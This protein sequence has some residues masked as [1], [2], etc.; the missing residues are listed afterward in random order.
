MTQGPRAE[1]LALA[2][3]LGTG[4]PKVA[5]V[6][7]DGQLRWVGQRESATRRSPDGTAVQDARLWW[8][9]VLSL[10]R[11]G[12]TDA[13][14]DPAT[15]VAVSVTGQWGSTVPVDERGEPV[16]DAR[17]FLDTRG[18]RHSRTVIGGPAMGYHPGRAL[19]WLRRTGG[20]PS[21]HGGDPIAH[22]LAIQHDEP[23]VAAAARWFLEPVDYL[24]M[25]FCGRAV[26]TPNSM[27]LAWLTD[28]RV[29]SDS[30]DYQPDLLAHSGIHGR[31][32]APLIPTGSIVGPLDP[33]VAELLGLRRA[34]VVLAGATDLLTASVGSGALADRQA[35]LAISTTSW[36]SAPMTVKKTDVL[37][38]IATVPGLSP[39]RYLIANN[40]ETAGVCLAWARDQ[41][42]GGT[43]PQLTAEA[44]TAAP[45]SGG[46]LF[47][48][49]LSGLRSPVDDRRARGGW[50]NASLAT[51]RAELIRSVMEGVALQ[52]GWLLQSVEKFA[53]ARLDPIRVI[54]GGAQSDLW[55][56]LHADV[57]D[58]RIER[59]ADPVNAQLRGAA[60]LAALALGVLTEEQVS[61]AGVVERVFTPDPAG[62]A[63]YR[64]VARAFRKL[65]GRQ[66]AMFAELNG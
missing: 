43:F 11:T 9:D 14:V 40:H 59:V 6:T 38:S 65:Y 7:L 3:D 52:S 37:H 39:G 49:W 30:L 28:N 55:C 21:P 35:H 26:A 66:K 51:T 57:L 56:Q 45:G 62:R 61:A 2:V 53:G 64:P 34:V 18:A 47:A 17:L 25:R 22:M 54:G 31:R 24:T 16:G 48:P 27:T 50:H 23:E 4:G 5:L 33:T 63:A 41:V 46:V 12:L 10:A 15:V 13:G 44:A 8:S 60:L 20:A 36:C 1:S 42:F 29:G 58:R 19:T 32:L